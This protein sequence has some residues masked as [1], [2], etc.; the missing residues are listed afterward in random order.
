MKVTYKANNEAHAEAWKCA[1]DHAIEIAKKYEGIQVDQID[2]YA[3]L[4]LYFR[5][6]G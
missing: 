1:L 5:K 3:F 6:F 2:E 4:F